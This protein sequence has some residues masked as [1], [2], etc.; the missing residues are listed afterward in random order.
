MPTFKIPAL[1]AAVFKQHE[2]LLR[3]DYVFVL[4]V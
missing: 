1:A 3:E 2:I 4:R